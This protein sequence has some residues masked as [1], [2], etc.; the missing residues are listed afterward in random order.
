VWGERVQKLFAHEGIRCTHPISTALD[1]RFGGDW[2]AKLVSGVEDK[3]NC[4]NFSSEIS[5]VKPIENKPQAKNTLG[6]VI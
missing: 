5:N 4:A 6:C 2:V 1:N 3:E